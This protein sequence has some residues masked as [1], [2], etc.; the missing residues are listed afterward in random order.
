MDIVVDAP[1]AIEIAEYFLQNHHETINLKSSK[2]DSATKEWIITFDVGF[3][4]E[5]IK[6]V[7]VDAEDGKILGYE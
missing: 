7:K 5:N 4:T 1:K 2:L 3:L 6:K